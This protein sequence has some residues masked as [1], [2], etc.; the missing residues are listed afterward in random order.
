M[1][2]TNKQY[3]QSTADVVKFINEWIE[4][5]RYYEEKLS[6]KGDHRLAEDCSRRVF[7]LELLLTNIH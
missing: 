5:E 1:E 4:R 3:E 6:L 2:T 7:T